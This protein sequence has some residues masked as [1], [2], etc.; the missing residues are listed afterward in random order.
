M[1]E[2][3]QLRQDSEGRNPTMNVRRLPQPRVFQDNLNI[4]QKYMDEIVMVAITVR[5]NSI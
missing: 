4:R 3:A 2:G 1:T 5:Q